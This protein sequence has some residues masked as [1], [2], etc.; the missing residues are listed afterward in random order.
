MAD[1]CSFCYYGD[2]NYNNIIKENI[3]T[4][5][6]ILNEGGTPHIRGG[7]CEGCCCTSIKI[8]KDK[9]ID[10]I[11]GLEKT[12]LGYI[13]NLNENNEIVVDEDSELFIKD[14]KIKKERYI[15]DMKSLNQNKDE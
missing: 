4:I 7:V 15:L 5:N 11:D 10:I 3:E 9:T 6:N 1:F 8:N 12:I 14:Y 13:G 2:I